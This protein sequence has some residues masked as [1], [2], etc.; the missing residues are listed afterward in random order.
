[1]ARRVR[2]SVDHN[3]CVGNTFCVQT[4]PRVFVLNESRQSEAK[5]P[6]GDTLER[7]LEAARNCPVSAIIVEDEETEE[8][9]FPPSQP[10]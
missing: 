1:M 10:R 6:R 8:R 5:N 9:L 4:A 2:V 7:I 3:L